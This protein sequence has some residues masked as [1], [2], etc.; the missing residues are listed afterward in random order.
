MSE[1]MR[2][3]MTV[4][5]N[6]KETNISDEC[7]SFT[8]TDCAGGEAD[9]ISM[10]MPNKNQ[11]WMKGYKPGRAD[12]IKAWIKVSNW[13]EGKKDAKQFCGKFYIDLIQYA[14]F[15]ERTDLSGI[16]VPIG[17]GFNVRQ[18]NKTWKKT[19]VRAVLEEIAKRAGIK[20][21]YDA[22]DH[23]IDS[24]SQN[25]KTDLEFAFDICSEYD[26]QL[27]IYNGK[28][29]VYDQTDYEKKEAKHTIKRTELGGG[30]SYSIKLQTTKVYNGVKIQYT[31]GKDKVL[32]YEFKRPGTNGTRQMF[33]TA[34]AESLQDAE[35]KAKAALRKNARE[36]T[37]GTIRIMGNPSYVAAQNIKLEGFGKLDGKYFIE[38]VIHT[39]NRSYTTTLYIHKT[40]TDF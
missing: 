26:R 19:S 22:A 25:G 10:Q 28:M 11:K 3:S 32:T 20:L 7:E 12:Y 16:S 29:V 21:Q 37:T 18:R 35:K 9:T 36:E 13:Q 14:G 30:E 17:N 34:K 38:K 24:I 4:K 23:K 15:P 1:A 33:V 6:E 2:S 31:S 8:W 5:Y 27:K 40:V 39:K